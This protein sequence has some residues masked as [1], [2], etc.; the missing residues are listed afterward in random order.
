MNTTTTTLVLGGTGKTGGRIVERLTARGV[1]VRVGSRS[2]EFPFDWTDRSTWAAA[3]A[4]VRR[5]YVS[6]YPDLA[7]P[8][9]VEAV[10]ALSEAARAAGVERLVLL[11]GRGEEEAQAAERVV[12][13][14]GLEW[15]IVRCAW[16]NQNFD[17]NYLLEPILAGEVALP[18]GDVPEPFVDADDIAD[19]AVAA[20]TE[21]GHVGELY[22]LTGPRLL[23]FAEAVAE[24]AKATG[25]E[26]AFVPVPLDDYSAALEAEG[27]PSDI[28]WLIGYLFREVLDGRNASLA[29]GVQRALG[30]A[31][32][33]FTDYARDAAATGV[34][35]A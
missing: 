1:D 3:L 27:L 17:E 2:G 23:T 34:W 7:I 18:A 9:A 21:D 26:I 25:R 32:K 14:S 10:T 28:A 30:R 5:V 35:T 19:V 13:E 22:E 11:S 20:L 12:Q 15:T 6:Y 29:D 31:P 16:F 33:D 8:G 24:I 4:G